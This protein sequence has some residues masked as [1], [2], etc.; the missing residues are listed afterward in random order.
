MPNG[1]RLT[2]RAGSGRIDESWS[3]SYPAP[4]PG[5]YTVIEVTDNGTGMD[6]ATLAHI[7]EPFF[8]T[9]EV[10]QG[11][12]LGL[13]TVY[14][15]VQQMGGAISAESELGVGT[16]FRIYLPEVHAPQA[17]A[18][19]ARRKSGPRGTET[20]LLAEDEFQIRR[21]VTSML[22]RA[23]YTV[24]ASGSPA[25]ALELA[26]A[27]PGAI[28]ILVSD[29]IMPGGTG[30]DLARQLREVRPGLQVLFMSGNADLALSR[31]DGSL[32]ATNFLQKPFT[33]D[34]LLS[35]VRHVLDE[36]QVA[37]SP[38]PAGAR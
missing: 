12:G 6:A 8:T 23:G 21:F 22:E 11:T 10:G 7:F 3:G 30:P 26:A 34:Q 25:E 19:P 4:K 17:A 37:A 18:K 33:P 32:D 35:Q 15:L 16:T 13:A 14:G 1:G 38:A 29:M 20:V 28:D 24:L 27:H 31:G 2:I 36:A 9:K 5:P